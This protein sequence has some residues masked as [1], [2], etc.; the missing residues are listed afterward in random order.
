MD[1][2]QVDRFVTPSFIEEDHKV[3]TSLRPQQLDDYIGQ[4][5]TKEKLSVFIGAAKMREEPLDHV[6]L[7][8][9]PGLGKTTLS[10]I[11]ANEMGVNMK[12]TS[13]PAIER[14]VTWQPF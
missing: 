12:V 13:G 10:G 5:K 7:Y 14:L 11:I 2:F 8:G 6:L 3:E 1:N 9:P 4:A